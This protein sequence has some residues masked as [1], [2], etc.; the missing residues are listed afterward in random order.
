MKDKPLNRSTARIPAA[1]PPRILQFGGGNFLRAFFDWMV[2]VMNDK[3]SYHGGVIVVKPT[4]GGAYPDWQAQDGLFF[5]GQRGFEAGAVVENYRLIT[6]V[7][8]INSPYED[9]DDFLATAA[10]P[11]IE[12]VV[13]NTTEAGLSYHPADRLDDRPA[14]SFP[15]KLTQWLYHRYTFF[16]GEAAKGVTVLPF[17]LIEDNGRQLKAIV[18]ELATAWQLEPGFFR[19]LDQHNRFCN[20]L[21]DRIVPGAPAGEERPAIEALT[22]FAD[23]RLVLAEPYH[24][25]VIE[26]DQREASVFPAR[27]AGLNVHVVEDITPFRTLKVRILNG[28]HTAMVPLGLLHGLETVREVIEDEELG[29][30]VRQLI[31]EEIIPT[32]DHQRQEAIGYANATI[33]RFRNP[34]LHHRLSDIALNSSAKVTAR[35]L[36]TFE[37]Y[38]RQYG[39]PPRRLTRALAAFIRFYGSRWKGRQLPVRDT[40]EA[41]AW[42]GK[43][44]QGDSLEEVARR[45]LAYWPF[46][47]PLRQ[48][49]EKAVTTAL[50]QLDREER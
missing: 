49:L 40:P 35:L 13:S 25:L 29:D 43:A 32:L 45:A 18:R 37:A 3:T 7:A 16:G 41:I 50:K 22:G 10:L 23:R 1:P 44:W 34:F 48:V 19:W 9:F 46:S 15:G 6:C 5:V 21:V 30:F 28:A 20:T 38:Y 31:S 27:T 33:E 14:A 17:E 2:E 11:G 47:A 12:L 24:L 39:E 26:D 36:P 42:F 4:P 8:A